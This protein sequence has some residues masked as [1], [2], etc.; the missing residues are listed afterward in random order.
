MQPSTLFT[1]QEFDRRNKW[2]TRH[3][4]R[5]AAWLDIFA[6]T[7]QCTLACRHVIGYHQRCRI[8]ASWPL[9]TRSFTRHQ[10]MSSGTSVRWSTEEGSIHFS[11]SSKFAFIAPTCIGAYIFN[12]VCKSDQWCGV[13]YH[14]PSG[15]DFLNCIFWNIWLIRDCRMVILIRVGL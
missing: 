14:G 12:N 15:L 7:D 4:S 10:S 8:A 9:L 13:V 5:V 6:I 1:A 3:T 11:A 2:P